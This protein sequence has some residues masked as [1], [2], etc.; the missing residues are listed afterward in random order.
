MSYGYH[1]THTQT[2]YRGGPHEQ[3]FCTLLSFIAPCDLRWGLKELL[4]EL[5]EDIHGKIYGTVN[6]LK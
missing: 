3:F 1:L 5:D 6:S 2:C 4:I